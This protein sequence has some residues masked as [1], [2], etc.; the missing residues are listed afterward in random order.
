M[1]G[2]LAVE[3]STVAPMPGVLGDETPGSEGDGAGDGDA[4][5]PR[6]ETAGTGLRRPTTGLDKVSEDEAEMSFPVASP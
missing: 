1:R 5:P 4:S 6:G 3:P 2:A